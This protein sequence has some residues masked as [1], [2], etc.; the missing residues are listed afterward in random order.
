[1]AGEHKTPKMR[2]LARSRAKKGRARRPVTA[3]HQNLFCGCVKEQHEKTIEKPFS[4]RAAASHS[5][6]VTART[7]KTAR[8]NKTQNRNVNIT[9]LLKAGWQD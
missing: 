1:M 3:S 4:H 6:N 8:A 7:M 9:N 5:H 2:A